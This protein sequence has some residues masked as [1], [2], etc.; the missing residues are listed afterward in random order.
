MA[1]PLNSL[2]SSLSG[3]SNGSV[4]PWA[5]VNSRFFDQIS[6]LP[7]N[8]DQLFPYRLLVIDTANNNAVVSGK[9]GSAQAKI[10]IS[11]GSSTNAIINFEAID[12][13]WV[14]NLPISPEQ[15]SMVDQYAITVTPT[16]RGVLE[17][18]GGLK[19]KMI[20][21]SGSFGVWPYRSSVTS[22]P[23]SPSVLQSFFGGTIEAAQNVATQFSNTIN[24]ITSNSQ[25]SPPAKKRPEQSDAGITST[26][27]YMAMALQQF[28]EQYAEAKKDPDNASWRLV[29]DIPK[30][31]TSYVV[32]PGAFQ[33]QQNAN[34][35]LEIH[36]NMQFKGWRRIDLQAS[37]AATKPSI[38]SISPGVLQRVLS[39]LS[40]ARA[41]AAA[42]LDL[43][44]AVRS[45]IEAPLTALRQTAL[46]VKDIAGVVKS[47]ADLPSQIIADYASSI[48]DSINIISSSLSSN[49]SDPATRSAISAITTSSSKVEGLSNY[50]VAGGQLGNTAAT[51]Q[52]L[53]PSNNVFSQSNRYFTLMDQ[54]PLHSLRLN[55]AQQSVVNGVINQARALTVA[56]LKV[57]RN[58]I[59]D[60][61]FQLSNNFG[62]GDAYYNTV[63]GKSAP[64]GR[65]Q[66]MTLDEYDILKSFY[67]VLQA[68]D[69]LTA[70]SAV[71]DLT[72]TSTIDFVAGLAHN[73]GIAFTSPTAKVQVPVPFGLT[74]EGIAARY[75][76]DPQRWLE[77]A[78]LNNIREPYID[79]DGFQYYLLS[80]GSSRQITI[81]SKE[82]LYEG[83]RVV[84]I[85][86]TQQADARTILSIDRLS[87]TSFLIT[88]DGTP[89][90]NKFLL[91][92][93]AYLQ[94]YLPGTVNSQQKIFIPSNLP[95]DQGPRVGPPSSEASTNLVGLS[96]V[97][98]LLTDNGDLAVNAYGDFRLAAGMTN[99]I[100]ALRMK[101]STEQGSILLHPEF[102]VGLK[103]GAMTSDLNLQGIYKSLNTMIQQDSRF[104]GIKKL[105]VQLNG[106][107]I[108]INMAVTLAGQNGVFPVSFT[109]PTT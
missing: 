58:T 100:Q 4:V 32:T 102:G 70:S 26:G 35:A 49:T 91:S 1:D 53:D 79:E 37:V 103:V 97:D 54:V 61:T 60:L 52:S 13:R 109:L 38:Q 21:A 92:D 16:L 8:W 11:G 18:H 69:I 89:N 48:K 27:Y 106:N 3:S 90:L 20:S 88:L 5:D 41:T 9:D 73:S 28:L 36:Y 44:G 63:Y 7:Q 64:T 55:S 51:A 76:G 39:A 17:E 2:T 104:Q 6:I 34:K 56:D 33:W 68:Y 67:D 99:L 98:W 57:Y 83:Q 65:I 105:Q 80:N 24:A 66:P 101:L 107:V 75:L 84:L 81:N 94:A 87:D 47:V 30:Q 31:N 72:T 42:S 74:M 93:K 78:T 22:P 23:S 59:Q 43:I 14:F 40:A 19:F 12:N 82:N 96:K 46:L 15:L 86:S 25:A 85:S 10:D 50:A 95:V 62:A 29:F 77:I 108:S 71:D 45:D